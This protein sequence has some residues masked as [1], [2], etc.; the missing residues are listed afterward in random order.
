M[1]AA[2]ICSAIASTAAQTQALKRESIWIVIRGT[3]GA[4]FLMFAD[5]D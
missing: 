2:S 1:P 4:N 3:M 5:G